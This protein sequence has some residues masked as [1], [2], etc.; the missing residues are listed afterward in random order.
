MMA[1]AGYEP[2]GNI[3]TMLGAYDKE[4]SESVWDVMALVVGES[5]RFI[6]LDSSLDDKIKPFVDKLVAAQVKRL[7]WDAVRDEPAADTKLRA[8][9]LGLSTYAD[10]EASVTKAKELFAAY[11]KDSSVVS[12][13]L[14]A[15][16]F[17]VPVKYGDDAAFDYLMKLHDGSQ[18]SDLKGDICDAL[19]ATRQ[20]EKAKVLLGRLKDAKLIK[21]QDVDR[22]LVY[23]LRNRYTRAV[24]WDWM[25]ANWQWLEDTFK[26][27]KSYDYL[28]RYAASCA[29][30][31]EYQQK[32]RELFE[33]KQ[34]QPLLKRNIQLGFEE[35][36]TRV[37]WLE[38][39]LAS[40]QKFFA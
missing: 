21:P 6:D 29:N 20:P 37:T 22:W 14:R 27:D 4:S 18:N 23:L 30:T 15:L 16:V 11:Q 26:N 39:D 12:A 9:V 28:P 10:N 34:D 2:Y 32:F 5:R 3:L 24:A 38:R 36:E 1:K 31:R 8:L 25:V 7:G 35:I 33:D 40:V 19:T 17:L 13:E